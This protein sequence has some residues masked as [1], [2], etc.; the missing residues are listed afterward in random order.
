MS[1][2]F[3]SITDDELPAFANASSIGFGESNAWFERERPWAAFSLE[4]TVGGFEGDTVVSTSRNY[5]LDLMLLGGASLHTAAVSA[6]TVL[7]T[8][9]RRGLLREM[10]TR[11]LDDAV[12]HEEPVSILTASEAT[13]YGRFGFGPSTRALSVR[14]AKR[15]LEFSRPR[16]EG[17]LRLVDVHEAG[18]VEP[19]VFERV[20]R[21]SPGAVSRP[22]LWW[23]H[24]YDPTFGNRFDVVYESPSGSVD[25]Y[26]TYSVRDKWDA[27]GAAHVLSIRELIGCT[28]DAVH[29]LWRYLGEIDL[30]GTI[31]DI[32]IPM[33]SP[34]PWLLTS[35]R[36]VGVN[37]IGDNLWTRLLDVP[38]ALGARTYAA[39]G[40]LVFAID[41][42]ARPGGAADGTF[43]LDGGPDGA[44][45]T[46]SDAEPDLVCDVSVASTAWLGGVRWSELAVAGL[47]EERSAGAL[48]TAD[49]M[50][51]STPLPYG[52]T[53][54]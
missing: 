13:I 40:R 9:R 43:A 3:R 45:V 19:E 15:D 34:L 29:A 7:P 16:P 37:S 1:F 25:G 2:T 52:Y 24:H 17:R 48:A 6:V 44:T 47:V 26:V 50:F 46:R 38:V 21:A 27:A 35:L 18:K 22:E 11:L 53:W 23:Y 42:P 39:T 49:A 5:P 31:I 33:D 10:M 20:W 51:A 28:P 4:R 30:V 41:D 14:I 8:H 12:E 32:S 36:A 54:F